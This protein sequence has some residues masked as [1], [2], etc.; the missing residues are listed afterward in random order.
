LRKPEVPGF[1]SVKGVVAT[2]RICM[3]IPASSICPDRYLTIATCKFRQRKPL[4]GCCTWGIFG[5]RKH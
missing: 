1:W 2:V 3:L 4:A 5:L